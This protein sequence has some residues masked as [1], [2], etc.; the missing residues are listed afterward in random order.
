MKKIL[1]SWEKRNLTIIGKILIIKSRI[2]PKFKL[3][4]SSCTVPEGYMKEIEWCCFTFIWKVKPVKIK[5]S[6]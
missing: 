5:R 6:Y 1:I 2:L 3:I 4:A